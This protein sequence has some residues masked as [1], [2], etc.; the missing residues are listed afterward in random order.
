[1]MTSEM[2]AADE[3]TGENTPVSEEYLPANSTNGV[4]PNLECTKRRSRCFYLFA[5]VGG[6]FT[7]NNVKSNVKYSY[8]TEEDEDSL[9]DFEDSWLPSLE[10]DGFSDINV[11]D[12]DEDDGVSAFDMYR[13]LRPSGEHKKHISGVVGV[14][15][16]R[17]FDN[18][19][20][21]A[22]EALLDIGSTSKIT[23]TIGEDM[24]CTVRS[25]GLIPS[26]AIRLGY[27]ISDW[28]DVLFYIKGGGAYIS[29]NTQFSGSQEKVKM[30]KLVPL[31]AVGVDFAVNSS[32]SIRLEGEHRFEGK[33][34]GNI[35]CS[36]MSYA[37][38]DEA[39]LILS[40]IADHEQKTKSYAVRLL[41]SWCI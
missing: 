22:V 29:G 36:D 15:Y 9:A 39:E 6:L 30:S 13:R 1:M 25:S 26:A 2:V 21:T 28:H 38:D 16:G 3:Y 10:E 4:Q 20:Y 32:V 34:S 5:G 41:V 40:R 19:C 31:V 7:E 11:T 8:E 14:G 12:S 23:K 27:K 17:L 37:S 35:V 24:E 18:G 33:K